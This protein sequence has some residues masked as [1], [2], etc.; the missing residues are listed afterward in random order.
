[1]LLKND[2]AHANPRRELTTSADG[3]KQ[4]NRPNGWKVSFGSS[5]GDALYVYDC[6]LMSPRPKSRSDLKEISTIDA[7][8]IEPGPP[9]KRI[10]INRINVKPRKQKYFP[11]YFCKS[12]L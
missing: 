10:L 5:G 12:E 6:A 11:F 7:R 9:G 2:I 3:H 4:T 1:L 8:Q